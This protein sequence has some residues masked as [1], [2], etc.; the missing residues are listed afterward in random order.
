MFKL[1]ALQVFAGCEDHIKKCLKAD[2][3]YYFCTDFRFDI[4]D[5]VY[6]GS[7][8]AKPLSEDFFTIPVVDELKQNDESTPQI[9]INAIVGKNGDGKSTIVEI[10]MRLVN[11][12]IVLHPQGDKNSEARELL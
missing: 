2:V 3:F 12:Y 9:N 7:K 5:K 10:I 6:R 1:L 11:N 4:S 8:Y